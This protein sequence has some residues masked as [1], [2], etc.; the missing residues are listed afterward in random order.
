MCT[1]LQNVKQKISKCYE[2]KTATHLW[3]FKGE[4]IARKQ[5]FDCHMQQAA[6]AVEVCDVAERMH[7]QNLLKILQ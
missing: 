5:G 1:D 4:D 7:V 3:G 2:K 6:I